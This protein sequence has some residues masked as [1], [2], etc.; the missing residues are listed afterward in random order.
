MLLTFTGLFGVACSIIFYLA[1]NKISDEYE[2]LI[3]AAY[4]SEMMDRNEFLIK[5]FIMYAVL[6]VLHLVNI[7]FFYTM[8]DTIFR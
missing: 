1:C 4:V 5:R 6:L 2:V 8:I 3:T 7:L